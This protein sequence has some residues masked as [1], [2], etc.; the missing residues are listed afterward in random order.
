MRLVPGK[1]TN[2][3]NYFLYLLFVINDCS[4][5]TLSYENIGC[6]YKDEFNPA[7]YSTTPLSQIPVQ[8]RYY[9]D[10]FIAAD[11]LTMG[12]SSST[13]TSD[14]C[15][16]MSANEQNTTGSALL[17][18]G[19]FLIIA[20]IAILACMCLFCKKARKKIKK[21]IKKCFKHLFV[22]SIIIFKYLI[23]LFLFQSYA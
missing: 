17:I 20:E 1:W 8:I 16:G 10:S 22:F 23:I 5:W 18:V 4:A 21:K 12:C 7:S 6:Y 11:E 2:L 19:A 15:F 14:S 13:S 3:R 9:K